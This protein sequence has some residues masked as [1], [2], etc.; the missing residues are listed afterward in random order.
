MIRRLREASIQQK[1]TWITLLT[2]G[3]ALLV[4]AIA[5]M[6]NNVVSIRKSKAADLVALSQVIGSNC[7]AAVLF[8]NGDD[9]AKM[10]S[11]LQA[12]KSIKSAGI[13]LSDGTL[14]AQH[15]RDG[16]APLSAGADGTRFRTDWSWCSR[17]AI[18]A[19]ATVRAPSICATISPT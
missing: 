6:A 8:R 16:Q 4:A 1:L 3:T 12:H 11:A 7:E 13:F 17:S 19:P 10:L 5:F 2:S 9:A 18:P 15:P 14:L